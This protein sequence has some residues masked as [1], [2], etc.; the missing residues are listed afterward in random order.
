MT[1]REIALRWW[2]GLNEDEKQAYYNK[3]VT[4][5]HASA[6]NQ[7]TGREIQEIWAKINSEK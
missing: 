7:L 4:C 1:K 2:N 5:D 6:H 3:Y